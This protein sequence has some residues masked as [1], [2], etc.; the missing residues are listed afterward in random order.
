MFV[1]EI[2]K[3][4]K[5][6]GGLEDRSRQIPELEYKVQYGESDY[7]FLSRLLEE[8]GIAFTFPDPQG[9]GAKLTF[10]DA[11]QANAPRAPLVFTDNP[12]QQ[13]EKELSERSPRAGRAAGS[14]TMRD[15]DFRRPGFELFGEAP[16][17]EWA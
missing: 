15:Y 4:W 3:E 7:A 5:L 10:G 1:E 6:D 11:L 13:A 2:L 17:A 9:G 12:N 8:A 14:F 16:P